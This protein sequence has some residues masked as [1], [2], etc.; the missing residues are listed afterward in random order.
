MLCVLVVLALGIWVIAAPDD[1]LRSRLSLLI[2]AAVILPLVGALYAGFRVA[3]RTGHVATVIEQLAVGNRTSRIDARSGDELGRIGAAMNR[4]AEHIQRKAD[5]LRVQFR[6]A[7]QE[8]ERLEAAI[9]NMSEGVVVLDMSGGVVLMNAP[10][11]AILGASPHTEDRVRLAAA[12]TDRLG[13]VLAPGVYALGDPL[14]MSVGE[15]VIQAQVAAVMNIDNARLGTVIVLRGVA[16]EE[17]ALHIK[18]EEADIPLE[19]LLWKVS[20]EWRQLAENNHI[21]LQ[22]HIKQRGLKVRGDVQRLSWALGTVMDNA[23]K[24]TPT[25]GT[26]VIQARDAENGMVTIRLRDSGVGIKR[27][28]LLHVFTR[29]YRGTPHTEDGRLVRVPGMG[30]GLATT[31]EIIEAHGGEVSV[32]SKPGAGTAV[33]ITLP[34][35]SEA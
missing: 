3:S 26:I 8:R 34:L 15:Q 28:E 14:R 16:S 13:E 35:A 11:R 5:D 20:N 21:D 7:R 27:E 6:Q 32:K 9:A 4:Y 29:F 2:A 22:V 31:K 12:V 24:Y 19:T 10:A 25:G 1:E 18:H 30:Q 23:L 33:Y 17:D